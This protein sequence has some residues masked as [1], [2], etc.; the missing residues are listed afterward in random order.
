MTPR[1]VFFI[2]VTV[3][4]IA[5]GAS[6]YAFTRLANRVLNYRT[7][8]EI[9]DAQISALEEKRMHARRIDTLLKGRAADLARVKASFVER[10]PIALIEEIERIADHTKNNLVLE[11]IEDGSVPRDVELRLSIEGSEQSVRAM[12]QLIELLPYQV[13]IDDL[14]FERVNVS[15]ASAATSLSATKGVSVP[16][17]RLTLHTRFTAVSP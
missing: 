17:A 15:G 10:R 12:L 2:T 6:A 13:S 16:S 14:T 9:L 5:L 3:S 8:L 4:C 7:T 1:T 11:I